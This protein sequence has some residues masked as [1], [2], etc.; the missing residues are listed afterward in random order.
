MNIISKSAVALT[1]L[2]FAG[3]I[4]TTATAQQSF[5]DTDFSNW[6]TEKC[7]N[8]PLSGPSDKVQ[9]SQDS[10]DGNGAPSLKILHEWTSRIAGC[11]L[12]SEATI[13]LSGNAA[14][15]LIFKFEG[16]DT[17]G[18]NQGIALA[19]LI[20]QNG[21]YYSPRFQ[22][23]RGRNFVSWNGQDLKASDFSPI[24]DFDSNDHPDFSCGAPDIEVGVLSANQGRGTRTGH[25]DNWSVE[26]LSGESCLPE[27]AD[28]LCYDLLAHEQESY[29]QKDERALL[30]QFG[31]LNVV[32]GNPVS[33]CNPV[34]LDGKKVPKT[35]DHYVCYSVHSTRDQAQ[36]LVE[37][38]N[39]L[40]TNRLQTGRSNE[41]CVRSS[42]KHLNE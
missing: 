39:T 29:A 21:R 22:S 27:P 26:S 17:L 13:S 8:V 38:D 1:V 40:E 2:T 20:K 33:I 16:R 41:L 14:A 28:Y 7:P 30:D 24:Y 5:E 37:V 31:E 3:A 32:V 10:S 19:P 18:I 11:H 12:N 36:Y 6:I 15:S 34:D 25:V 35:E 23:F 42:K 9:S 4:G